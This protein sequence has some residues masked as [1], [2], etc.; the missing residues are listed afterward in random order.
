MEVISSPIF[1]PENVV[2]LDEIL[3]PKQIVIKTQVST[4]YRDP[5]KREA[6]RI[7]K[8]KNKEYKQPFMQSPN[9][10]QPQGA[11]APYPQQGYS[12]QQYNNG[13]PQQHQPQ[14]QQQPTNYPPP[15]GG[16]YHPP[17]HHNNAV[18][19]YIREN[20]MKIPPPP[21]DIF[22]GEKTF[23][24]NITP[25]I[26]SLSTSI[27]VGEGGTPTS[28]PGV[29][30][31]KIQHVARKKDLTPEQLAETEGYIRLGMV[32]LI[33][34]SQARY[35]MS[36]LKQKM[37]NDEEEIAMKRERAALDRRKFGMGETR[38]GSAGMVS[39]RGE[40]EEYSTSRRHQNDVDLDDEV[41]RMNHEE[42]LLNESGIKAIDGRSAARPS[43]G[44]SDFFNTVHS[45]DS[46]L[47]REIDESENLDDLTG[48]F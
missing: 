46:N 35:E 27:I 29:L 1:E 39:Y 5:L 23:F 40:E 8:R 19:L 44:I 16:Y 47:D 42:M 7:K 33:S 18:D 4:I 34:E 6:S 48:F 12:P 2:Y 30:V 17:P 11:P 26:L 31:K 41:R 38:N 20:P 9:M 22:S 36:V 25:K 3:S 45:N 10:M 24:K 28:A 37:I 21:N 32:E 15:Q 13:Y 14:Q 43:Q